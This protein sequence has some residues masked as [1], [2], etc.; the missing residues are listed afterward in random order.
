MMKSLWIAAIVAV[1][2]AEVASAEGLP[3]QSKLSQLGLSSMTVVGDEQGAEVRGKFLGVGGILS[4]G[5]S[6]TGTP[7]IPGLLA[8][9]LAPGV[10]VFPT[11]A[12]QTQIAGNSPRALGA[13]AFGAGGFATV[14]VTTTNGNP[15]FSNF[16]NVPAVASVADVSGTAQLSIQFFT[17]T[18][19]N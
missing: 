6:T 7:G 16:V 1:I 8:P 5:A 17:L 18:V 3:S 2:G 14:D 11:I 15:T 4:L 13:S 19:G 9:I 10:V 12:A